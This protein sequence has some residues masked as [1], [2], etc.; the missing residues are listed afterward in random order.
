MKYI[1]NKIFVGFN[2]I[3]AFVML[4]ALCCVDSESMIPLAVFCG[5]GAYLAAVAY[6]NGLFEVER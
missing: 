5:S 3:V 4:F 2:F 1:L 6:F